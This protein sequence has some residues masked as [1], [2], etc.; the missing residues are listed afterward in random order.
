MKTGYW[1]SE[2]GHRSGVHLEHDGKPACGYRP[3]K[4]MRFHVCANGIY[5]SWEMC[6]KCKLIGSKIIAEAKHDT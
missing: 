1:A 2:N 5:L 3:A 6:Q 4:R